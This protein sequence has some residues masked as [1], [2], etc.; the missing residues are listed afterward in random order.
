SCSSSCSDSS[1]VAV[2][3]G[4]FDNQI[5]FVAMGEG[6]REQVGMAAR[7]C[8]V[9]CELVGCADGCAIYRESGSASQEDE[10]RGRVFGV[11]EEAWSGVRREICVW[12]SGERV[13]R[14]APTALM[15][16]RIGYPALTRWANL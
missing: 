6:S 1:D 7:L 5:E 13:M 10:F 8:G 9:Q 4:G 11:V 16:I 2:G 14:V 15:F 3:K 12:V